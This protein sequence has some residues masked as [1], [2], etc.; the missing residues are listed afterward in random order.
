MT[1]LFETK[2]DLEREQ[3][4]VFRFAAFTNSVPYKMPMESQADY[5]MMRGPDA[6]AIVEI[7]CRTTRSDQYS[8]YMIGEKKYNALC[9]WAEYGF[10]P[11][12]LISWS[13]GIGYVKCPVEHKKSMQGKNDRGPEVVP[14]PVILIDIAKFRMI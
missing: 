3:I 5:I 14:D 10:Q 13:D 4:A 8:E 6:K 11:I 9:K 1:K 2:E 7:K 12:L